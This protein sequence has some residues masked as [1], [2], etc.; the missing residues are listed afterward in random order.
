VSE[1]ILLTDPA[2][3]GEAIREGDPPLKRFAVAL[4][5]VK[6]VENESG[7][8]EWE[9]RHMILETQGE[10]SDAAEWLAQKMTESDAQMPKDYRLN[11]V[12]SLEIK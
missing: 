2:D 12:V 9:W 10:T 8:G 11:S 3:N 6:P 4:C 5:F 1:N 7:K